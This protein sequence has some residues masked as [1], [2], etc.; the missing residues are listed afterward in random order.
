MCGGHRGRLAIG[1]S[2][3]QRDGQVGVA[4]DE[5]APAAVGRQPPT[6]SPT[7]CVGDAGADRGHHAGEVDAQL[8]QVALEAGVAAEGDQHVGEVDARRADRDL[9]LTRSRR[10]AFAGN[11]FQ[12]AQIAG[13]ADLQTHAVA[14]I[15]R[16]GGVPLLGQ[17]RSR[18]QPRGVPLA[19]APCGLVLVGPA[20][21]LLRQLLG[22]CRLVDV[23]LGG[24]QVRML[25]ADHPDQ[26]AQPG[27]LQVG[28][29]S[30]GHGVGVARHDVEPG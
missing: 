15:V 3:R 4:G 9:D 18:A 25:G 7:W 2:G 6:R 12:S 19:V 23:D 24:V 21:Q 16:D 8:G 13:R 27:L 5:G 20:E 17:Q 10:D 29:L 26:S 22:I 30:R 14:F 28:D 11:E 1:Q